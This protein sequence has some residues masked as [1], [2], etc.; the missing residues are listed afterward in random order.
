MR[1]IGHLPTEANA[2][3]FSDFLCVEG[4]G[5]EVESEHEGWAVWI[6]SEDEWQK[7]RDLLAAFLANPRDARFADKSA[8]AR[9]LRA[10]ATAEVEAVE[11]RTYDRRAI[12]RASMSYSV[13]PLTAILMGLCVALAVLAW[14]GY[15]ERILNELLLTKV[16]LT[17]QGVKWFIGLP[18]IRG[19]EFWRLLTP[20]FVHTEP[21]HLIFNMLWLMTLGSMIEARLGLGL[22]G[23]L[24]IVIGVLSN[25]AQ[26]YQ[27]SP[28]FNGFSG[29]NYGLFG[30]IW[31]R[32]LR[33][34]RS[35]LALSMQTTAMMVIWFFLCL[36]GVIPGVA[37]MAHAAGLGLG[38]VWGF[39]DSIRGRRRTSG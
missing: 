11:R 35:G 27:M 6:H 33:D 3:T 17:D 2:T 30:Y 7:A 4:I 32:G 24:V 20:A 36:A 9:E 38:L 34:P 8:R 25:L 12:F 15:K 21:L 13:G 31:V 1:L 22:L 14:S 29:V 26:Y 23:L 5:N 28:Y 10:S 18:E 37:N 19:G 39:L 16:L